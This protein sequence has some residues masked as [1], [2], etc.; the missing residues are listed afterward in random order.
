MTTFWLILQWILMT[1]GLFCTLIGLLTVFY[2]LKPAKAPADPSNSINN[3]VSWWI[4]LTRPDILARTYQLLRNDVMDNI[5][6]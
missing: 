3:V 2:W 5:D 1:A 4:G 6:P